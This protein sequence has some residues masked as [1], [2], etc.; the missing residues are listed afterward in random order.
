MA[1]SCT[2]ARVRAESDEKSKVVAASVVNE[3]LVEG[4]SLSSA[5]VTNGSAT[6]FFSAVALALVIGSVASIYCSG[7]FVGTVVSRSAGAN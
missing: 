2:T 7:A 6:S 3:T 1:I 5:Q 4:G